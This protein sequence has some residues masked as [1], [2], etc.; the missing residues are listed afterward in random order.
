MMKIM[1]STF[2]KFPQFENSCNINILEKSKHL[3][4][5]QKKTIKDSKIRWLDALKDLNNLT[6]ILSANEFFDALPIKQFIKK[7][8]K[9]N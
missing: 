7:K 9:N 2:H 3:R 6:C 4:K 8:S 5:I 1:S